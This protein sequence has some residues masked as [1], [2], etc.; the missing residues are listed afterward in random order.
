MTV[1]PVTAIHCWQDCN[2]RS[3]WSRKYQQDGGVIEEDEVDKDD[4][5]TLTAE[6]REAVAAVKFIAAHLKEEDDFAEVKFT[7]HLLIIIFFLI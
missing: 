1:D 4:S 7:I 2:E 5:L 3:S 6:T